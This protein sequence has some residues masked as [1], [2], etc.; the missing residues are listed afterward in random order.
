MGEREGLWLAMQACPW[1]LGIQ[2]GR[3]LTMMGW[4]EALKA[5]PGGGG[6]MV[7]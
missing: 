6:V 7:T 1:E 2:A 3:L 5:P 4:E